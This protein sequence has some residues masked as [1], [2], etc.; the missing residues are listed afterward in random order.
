L[1]ETIQ[2]ETKDFLSYVDQNTQ[3]LRSELTETIEKAQMELNTV[4]VSLYKRT[5]DVEK[6]ITS[7][8]EDITSTID[9]ASLNW[10][11]SRPLPGGLVD[12]QSAQT[13]LHHQQSTGIYREARSGASARS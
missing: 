2:K 3:N 7:I 11:R 10:K 9:S 4:E 12:Q 6:K 1:G 8:E 13:Q 5:R